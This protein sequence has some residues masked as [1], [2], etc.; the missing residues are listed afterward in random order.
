MVSSG[1]ICSSK[2]N[3]PIPIVDDRGNQQHHIRADIKKVRSLDAK[4]G[5]AQP[6]VKPEE[7]HISI[8]YGSGKPKSNLMLDRSSPPSG[9]RRGPLVGAK[10][11]KRLALS[12][13]R[14]GQNPLAP[15]SRVMTA[16][17]NV[18]ER[19]REKGSDAHNG[20]TGESANEHAIG[21]RSNGWD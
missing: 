9:P 13:A 14:F 17:T 5:S 8:A 4:W 18:H 1:L 11:C 12:D 10:E 7:G 16:A 15:T 20:Q 3:L 19:G 6:K 2:R 21:S